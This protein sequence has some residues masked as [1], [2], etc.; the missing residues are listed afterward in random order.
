MIPY[1]TVFC[2]ANARH[3]PRA[4]SKDAKRFAH[5]LVKNNYNL[6][7]GGSDEKL[8]HL[9]ASEV[10]SKGGKI[11]GVSMKMLSQTA[12]KGADEMIFAYNHQHR[13]KIM[14]K[15][16]IATV[17]LPG[18]I[19]TLDEI[20]TALELKKHD[21]YTKPIIFL[22]TNNFYR[23]LIEM[24]K[25]M[26]KYGFIRKSLHQLLY[27]AKTPEEVISYLNKYEKRRKKR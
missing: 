25:T 17:A 6:V 8:M 12:F 4:F 14:F 21:L 19:G 23:N 22:N 13:K 11:F 20:I 1:V 2:S 18:G 9:I 27:V 15:K 3:I 7:W 10:K 26:K 5:L 24:I 16:G